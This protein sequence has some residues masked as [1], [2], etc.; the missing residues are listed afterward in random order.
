MS[1]KS[2]SKQLPE[3]RKASRI[4]KPIDIVV[5]CP[6]KSGKSFIE[7]TRTV[8]ISQTGAKAMTSYEVAPGTRLQMAVPHRKKKSWATVARIGGKDGKLLEIGIALD[9]TN[10]FWGVK[11]A[12]EIA[13]GSTSKANGSAAANSTNQALTLAQ[14]L[15][16]TARQTSAFAEADLADEQE[17]ARK[18]IEAYALE[19]LRQLNEQAAEIMKNLQEVVTHQADEHLQ[20]AIQLTSERW[21]RVK[22][23]RR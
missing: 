20:R 6:D 18:A 19:A 23:L 7:R 15:L 16:A 10:D 22:C 8:D 3:K 11:I 1:G 17:Q 5:R 12:E 14:E 4:A 9:D 2:I 13:K 21:N